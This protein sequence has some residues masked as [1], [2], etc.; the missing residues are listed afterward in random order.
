M[1]SIA[2]V[3]NKFILVERIALFQIFAYDVLFAF[4][5]NFSS[6]KNFRDRSK[7]NK[8]ICFLDKDIVGSLLHRI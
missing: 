3:G 7:P 5:L 1:N 2:L 6:S 8:H 4:Q